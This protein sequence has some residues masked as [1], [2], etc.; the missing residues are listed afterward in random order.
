M[1]QFQIPEQK[2]K[3]RKFDSVVFGA[4]VG[5]LSPPITFTIYY[6]IMHRFVPIVSY[7]KYLRGGDI[8]VATLS[9]CVVPN[10]LIFFTFIWTDRDKSSKGVVFA[11]ILYAF[12]VAIMKMI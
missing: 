1:E 5:L 12:Y 10:L 3:K 4:I 2:S 11:T 9:L 8:F 7:I 6:F